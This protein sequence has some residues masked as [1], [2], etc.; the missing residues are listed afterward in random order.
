MSNF[1]KTTTDHG[2]SIFWICIEKFKNKKNTYL[3]LANDQPPRHEASLKIDYISQIW[4]NSI[5]LRFG[6]HLKAK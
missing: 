6:R 5:N 1:K 2:I 4:A 3:R